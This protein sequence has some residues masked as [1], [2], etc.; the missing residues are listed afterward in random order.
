MRNRNVVFFPTN[1]IGTFTQ[2]SNLNLKGIWIPIGILIDTN[3]SDK[4]KVIYS[5]IIFLSK[6]NC[7]TGKLYIF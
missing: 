5:I 4:E 6:G 7:K 1:F 3:L 2:M